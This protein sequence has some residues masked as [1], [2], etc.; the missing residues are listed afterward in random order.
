MK[1]K[2]LKFILNYLQSYLL[3]GLLSLLLLIYLVITDPYFH[4]LD[5]KLDEFKTKIE[6]YL[7][8]T[9][10]VPIILTIVFVI[11]QVFKKSSN[12]NRIIILISSILGILTFI[13]IDEIIKKNLIY[14]EN[15]LLG[16]LVG[17]V[18]YCLAF[19]ITYKLNNFKTVVQ[20]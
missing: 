4:K 8:F 15:I 13:I 1:K 20:A 2:A 12:N 10:N 3:C 18:L 11:F 7:L 14:P 6:L 16:L 5:F 19:V 9:F 17:F